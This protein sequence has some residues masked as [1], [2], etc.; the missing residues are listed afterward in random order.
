MTKSAKSHPSM[1]QKWTMIT[2]MSSSAGKWVLGSVKSFM[3]GSLPHEGFLPE[4]SARQFRGNRWG[5]EPTR[6]IH[7]IPPR[8]TTAQKK[9][10]QNMSAGK[11]IYFHYD[12]LLCLFLPRSPTFCLAVF[13][14]FIFLATAFC[15]RNNNGKIHFARHFPIHESPF[16]YFTLLAVHWCSWLALIVLPEGVSYQNFFLF[17]I[18]EIKIARNRC[19]KTISEQFFP[20]SSK[21][22]E[23]KVISQTPLRR[24]PFATQAPILSFHISAFN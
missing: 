9:C 4:G 18:D 19:G 15:L 7:F 1:H 10:A 23:Q 13:L 22:E 17:P 6:R 14:I 16:E 21:I 12:V 11:L 5:N 3:P 2:T 8:A 24:P 20:Q